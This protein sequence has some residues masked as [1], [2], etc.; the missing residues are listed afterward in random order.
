MN[1]RL[2]ILQRATAALLAPLVLMHLLVILYAS[3]HDLSAAA[4]LGRTR[5]SVLWGG[6]Y[7]LFVIAAATHAAI[8]L[9]VIAAE[10]TGLGRRGLEALMWAAFVL[11]AGLGL[12]AVAAVVLA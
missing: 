2:Y 7:G 11:L 9:R 12:L 1:L 4:I 8:G 6:F 3:G 5:G 10:W